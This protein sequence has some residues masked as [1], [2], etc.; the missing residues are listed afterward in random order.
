[1]SLPEIWLLCQDRVS[2]LTEPLQLMER[3]NAETAVAETRTILL[4]NF[5]DVFQIGQRQG[6]NV[7]ISWDPDVWGFIRWP[8]DNYT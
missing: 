7:V 1:M 2:V 5:D 8:E 3:Y 4:S 6:G